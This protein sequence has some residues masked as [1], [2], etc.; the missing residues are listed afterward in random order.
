MA[1][2]KFNALL[3]REERRGYRRFSRFAEGGLGRDEVIRELLDYGLDKDFLDKQEDED[4][5]HLLRAFAG[6]GAGD[7]DGADEDLDGEDGLDDGEDEDLGDEDGFDEGGRQHHGAGEQEIDY[8]PVDDA[9]FFRP[10]NSAGGE[11][12]FSSS[13]G[14]N[15]ARAA[16]A[17]FKHN[18]AEMARMGIDERSFCDAAGRASEE[19]FGEMRRDWAKVRKSSEGAP[20]DFRKAVGTAEAPAM[21]RSFAETLRRGARAPK[22]R[23]PCCVYFTEGRGGRRVRRTV[24]YGKTTR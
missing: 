24:A 1:H 12:S 10:G 9:E 23:V 2:D 20:E 15:Q 21:H 4:L 6:E 7:D 16:R 11:N 13:R 17:F 5:E 22:G 8:R 3:R 14:R 18:E 19:A